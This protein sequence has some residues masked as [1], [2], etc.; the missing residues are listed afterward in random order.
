MPTVFIKK[1]I[2]I[3]FTITILSLTGCSVGLSY[4][5]TFDYGYDDYYKIEG[6]SICFGSNQIGQYVSRKQVQC[7]TRPVQKRKDI[8][9][10]AEKSVF[11]I[12]G[13]G[14][15]L[16]DK[17]EGMYYFSKEDKC[18]FFSEDKEVIDVSCY[19]KK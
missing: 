3:L 1:Q 10:D 17:K 13:V 4:E 2:K 8:G 12:D 5:Q 14:R 19:G 6:T 9:V 16:D 15:L 7:E 11:L 18:R